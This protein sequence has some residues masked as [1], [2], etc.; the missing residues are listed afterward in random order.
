[1]LQC[2]NMTVFMMKCSSRRKKVM[3]ECYLE[4]M[5][6]RLIPESV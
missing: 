6:K 2:M 4:E 5:T 1:M 3:P